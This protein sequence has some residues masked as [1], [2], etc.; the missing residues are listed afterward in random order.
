[1]D[2][3]T[4]ACQLPKFDTIT[5]I[6]EALYFFRDGW[7]A[8]ST[9]LCK[10]FVKTC[11]LIFILLNRNYWKMPSGRSDEGVVGPFPT[12]ERWPALPAVIDSAFEDV[13]TKKVY[14]FSGREA[15]NSV[16]GAMTNYNADELHR[17]F[18]FQCRNTILGVHR[19]KCFGSPQHW[20]ARPPEQPSEGG[21]GTAEGQR[22]SAALQW[23]ELLEVSYLKN[24][25]Q[26]YIYNIKSTDCGFFFLHCLVRSC[27]RSTQAWCKGSEN[28]CRVPTIYRRHLWWSS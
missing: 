14:F 13:L 18:P 28:R 21:G 10:A 24:Y 17:L 26:T 2:P 7:A 15:S 6:E 19:T 8:H 9:P 20:E 3:T 25:Q 4:D 12:S 16:N 11:A 27:V 23:R 5:V 1:M 22:Q